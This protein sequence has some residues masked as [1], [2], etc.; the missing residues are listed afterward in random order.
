MSNWVEVHSGNYEGRTVVV[1]KYTA[2]D[3]DYKV[4]TTIK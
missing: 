3:N 1:E 2:S 4:I